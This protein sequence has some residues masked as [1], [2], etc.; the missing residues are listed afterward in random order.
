MSA[1]D[2]FDFDKSVLNDVYLQMFEVENN[3]HYDP[4]YGP[5][6][7]QTNPEHLETELETI[8][9]TV[10]EDSNDLLAFS[11]KQCLPISM[12]PKSSSCLN[13]E[14]LEP[15]HELQDIYQFILPHPRISDDLYEK[16]N[17]YQQE[18]EILNLEENDQGDQNYLQNQYNNN[19][20]SI[21]IGD[22]HYT[23]S[24]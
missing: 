10:T 7:N 9:Q 20:K 12:M 15:R 24:I 11:E 8:Y 17:S 1:S 13:M 22:Q 19:I 5:L 6:S 14:G 2:K 23:V 18:T 21:D 4:S 3:V 16:A